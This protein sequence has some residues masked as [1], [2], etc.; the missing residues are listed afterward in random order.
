MVM[1]VLVYTQISAA[2]SSDRCTMSFAARPDDLARARA[3]ASVTWPSPPRATCP[4]RRT[5]RI[6]VLRMP[7]IAVIVS[8]R[9]RVGLVVHLLET[10][11]RRMSIHLR[12][13]ERGVTQQLLDGPQ[14]GAGVEQMRS[15]RVA[16]RVYMQV[17]SRPRPPR[18]PSHEPSE[19]PLDRELHAARRE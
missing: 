8:S 10:L 12:G 7:L 16:Q 1:C 13:A 14:V 6:V 11:H 18:A 9:P 2:I 5:H 15:E 4:S 3:A 19:Q 17:S